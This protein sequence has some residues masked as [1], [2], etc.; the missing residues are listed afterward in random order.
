MEGI[1]ISMFDDDNRE[2]TAVSNAEGQHSLWPTDRA[3][4]AG[5]TAVGT[6]GTR[7]HCLEYI[8]REW[9]DLRPKSLRIWMGG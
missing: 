4:P 3:I 9:T 8:S 6:A 1:P 5:W 2:F 7:T